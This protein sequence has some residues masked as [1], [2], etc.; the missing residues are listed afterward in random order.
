[1]DFPDWFGRPPLF[2]PVCSL[3]PLLLMP[4]SGAVC[5]QRTRAENKP[6]SNTITDKHVLIKLK[7]ASRLK[8][9]TCA[10]SLPFSTSRHK[11]IF[12]NLRNPD[13]SRK[14]YK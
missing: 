13:H 14:C 5:T 9:K 1:M 2:G 6:Q 4:G 12:F 3:F 10:Q 7:G 11:N 8:N